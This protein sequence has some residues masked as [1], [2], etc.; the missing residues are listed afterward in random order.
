M[1]RAEQADQRAFIGDAV[2]DQKTTARATPETAVADNP[3]GPSPESIPRMR[4]LLDQFERPLMA[5]AARIVGDVDSARDVVQETFLRLCREDVAS[6]NGHLR[7][8]LYTVCRNLALDVCRKNGRMQTLSDMT[9]RTGMADQPPAMVLADARGVDPSDA[10]ERREGANRASELVD[11]LPVNQREVV[12]LRFQHDLSYKEIAAV[13]GLSVGN[14]G[15]LIHTAMRAL[16]EGMG[17]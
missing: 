9:G 1:K 11:T 4:L 7:Q 6:R 2:P 13:T 8:W 12:R 10:I 3:S 14:V 17:A 16:R 5:Y 15:F